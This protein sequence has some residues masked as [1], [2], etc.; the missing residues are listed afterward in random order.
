ML[1]IMEGE[2]MP[3]YFHNDTFIEQLARAIHQEYV[4]EMQARG[5]TETANR[6]IVSWGKLPRDLRTVYAVRAV[7]IIVDLGTI[8]A[9]VAPEYATAPEFRFTDRE[10]ED[11]AEL[12]HERWRRHRIAEGKVYGPVRGGNW[13]P[14]LVDWSVLPESERDKTR[15]AIREIPGILHH[16]GYEI[17][18]LLRSDTRQ[19]AIP[20]QPDAV[21]NRQDTGD[22]H[23]EGIGLNNLGLALQAMGRF[24]EAITVYQEAVAIYRHAGDRHGEDETLNNLE[25]ARTQRNRETR[26]W[27]SFR[28]KR[29]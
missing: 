27:R 16:M 2:C 9:V 23:H 28:R 26:W 10:V 17:L 7:H 15:I 11:L 24:E 21:A 22:Q 1:E 4:S 6:S 20:V 12:E 18:R 8:N 3:A 19:E 29:H 14:S 25:L 5:E 13:H